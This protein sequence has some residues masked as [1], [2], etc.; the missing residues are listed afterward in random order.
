[1]PSERKD[2]LR[3]YA[4]MQRQPQRGRPLF[5]PATAAVIGIAASTVGL[6]LLFAGRDGYH[7][8]ELYFLDA[9]HH[10]AFGT[11]TSLPYP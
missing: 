11:W 7:R 5:P 2:C 1:M 10:L 4:S 8:D 6:L 9:S 3:R